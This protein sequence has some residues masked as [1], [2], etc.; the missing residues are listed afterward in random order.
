MTDEQ[1]R[2]FVEAAHERVIGQPSAIE[3]IKDAL[4]IAGASSRSVRPFATFLFVG[5]IGAGRSTMAKVMADV[6][7]G[8]R[9]AYK[10]ILVFDSA[11][12]QIINTLSERP[13]IGLLRYA[14]EVSN[15]QERASLA[16]VLQRF[17]DNQ[18]FVG[19]NGH[20]IELKNSIFVVGLSARLPIELAFSEHKET[21]DHLRLWLQKH[22]ND[23]FGNAFFQNFD[24]IIPFKQFDVAAKTRLAETKIRELVTQQAAS[25]RTLLVDNSVAAYVGSRAKDEFGALDVQ[26]ALDQ[27]VN[28]PFREAVEKHEAD[29]KSPK[30]IRLHVV[31]DGIR[32]SIE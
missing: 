30:T 28:T 12:S 9:E 26:R 31:E 15:E 24:A 16:S 3:K 32:I 14:G 27:F 29:G 23:K 19:R 17:K 2:K 6:F 20:P 1:L 11:E 4:A 21:E 5:G 18:P 25:G 22:F 7:F 8:T 13:C 10:P